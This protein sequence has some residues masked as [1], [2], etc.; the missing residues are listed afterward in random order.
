MCVPVLPETPLQK[1][2]HQMPKRILLLTRFIESLQKSEVFKS[3]QIYLAFLKLSDKNDWER[4]IKQ[5][6]A[7][8]VFKVVTEDGQM[9]CRNRDE[10]YQFCFNLKNWQSRY[11]TACDRAALLSKEIALKSIDIG[12]QINALSKQFRELATLN[13]D[14]GISTQHSMFDL[15]STIFES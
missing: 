7:E 13:Q 8:K 1:H 14:A 9:D 4:A 2:L 6:E 10:A 11:Q 3:T 5:H 15:L 12:I